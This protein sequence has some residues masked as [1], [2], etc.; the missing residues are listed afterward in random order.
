M[1]WHSKNNFNKTLK[2]SCISNIKIFKLKW[3]TEFLGH[4]M[5]TLFFIENKITIVKLNKIKEI[6]VFYLKFFKLCHN[7]AI[8]PLH[9]GFS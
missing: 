7:C 6:K 8:T 9:I 2:K 1:V 4:T 5:H 3:L